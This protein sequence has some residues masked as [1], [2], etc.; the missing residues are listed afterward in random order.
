MHRFRTTILLLSMAFWA[1][2]QKEDHIWYFGPQGAGLDFSTCAPT[3]LTDGSADGMAWEGTTGICD[4]TTGELLF[5]TSGYR[6][7]NSL[8]QPMVNGD[9]V[10]LSNSLAQ[11]AI[12]PWP[13]SLTKYFLV[14]PEVQ[15]GISWMPN[16]PAAFSLYYATIDMSLAGGLGAVESKFNVLLTTPHCEFL[17]VVPH[18]NGTDFWLI[19]HGFG[20]N[21]F[22]VFA[23]TAAGIAPV[24]TVQNVGPV[25]ETPQPG[26]PSSSNIDAVGSIRASPNG[27]RLAFT[28]SYNGI[29]CL[30]DFDANTGTISA[31]IPLSIPG[32]AYGISFSPDGS[33]LFVSVR[34]PIM[35][36]TFQDGALVQF[37]LSSGDPNTIQASMS[38]IHQIV[39][40]GGFATLK[41][42]PDRKLY[43]ARVSSG[44]NGDADQYLGVVH[45]PDQAGSACNYVHNGVWLNGLIGGWGLNNSIEYGHGC[46]EDT[47]LPEKDCDGLVMST[48]NGLYSITFDCGRTIERGV[49]L[50]TDGRR[51]R[52]LSLTNEGKMATWTMPSVAQGVYLVRLQGGEQAAVLPFFFMP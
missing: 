46:G 18:A 42:G 31:P 43:V 2:G 21:T 13:G 14:I 6:V 8:R 29:T 17:T 28:T 15:G 34:S 30:F 38:T 9:P 49:V 45:E 36:N 48:L 10:G 4:G 16:D 27:T 23:I 24:P 20:T 11:M 26:A 44:G 41:L 5:Y 12:V 37:D 19:A 32:G 51:V 7:Y 52:D 35:S 40:N 47:S 1:H 50:T 25:V 39:G 3:V 22:F 33:K